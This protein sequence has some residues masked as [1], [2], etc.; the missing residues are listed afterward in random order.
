MYTR[1]LHACVEKEYR[2]GKNHIV[3]IGEIGDEITMKIH[4]RRTSRNKIYHTAHHKK[5][6]RNNSTDDASYLR[7]PSY[8][9]KSLHRYKGSKPIYAKHHYYCINLI[10]CQMRI[11]HM[12]HAYERKRYSSECK[13]CGKPYSTFNPL[14]PYPQEPGFTAERLSYPPE[15][16]PLLVRKHCRQFSSDKRYRN[17]K[18]QCRKQIVERGAHSILGFSRQTTQRNNRHDVHYHKGEYTELCR[19]LHCRRFRRTTS[20]T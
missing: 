8:P 16:A 12:V 14:K 2:R 20:D 17:Q 19:R 7:D 1:H 15:H 5:T 18:Y 9:A 11:R 13:H 10:G 3:K 6:C 4:L